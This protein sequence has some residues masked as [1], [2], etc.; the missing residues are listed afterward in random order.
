MRT[1]ELKKTTM[2]V[3]VAGVFLLVPLVV[4]AGP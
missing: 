1:T 3:L 2:V 4:N